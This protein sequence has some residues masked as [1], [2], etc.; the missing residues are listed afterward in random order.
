MSTQAT[1][2]RWRT[3]TLAVTLLACHQASPLGAQ[4]AS[5]QWAAIEAAFLDQFQARHPSIAAGNG[6]HAGDGGLEDFSADA[7]AVEVAHLQRLKGRIARLQVAALSPDQRVDARILDG[8]IDGWLLDLSVVKNWAR[9]PMIYASA[10]SDGVHNLMVMDHAPAATRLRLITRKLQRVP[11]FLATAQRNIPRPP[12]IFAQRAATFL[13]GAHDLISKDLWVWAATARITD[14]SALSQ[15]RAVAARADSAIMAYVGVLDAGIA[16]GLD[17]Q[18]MVG[19]SAVAARFRAEELLD[20]PLARMLAIGDSALAAEQSRFG[21]LAAQVDP[22]IT[23][24]AVWQK[25]RQRH[26]ARGE[27]VGATQRVVDELTTFVR[28][29]GLAT[30]PGRD[31]VTVAP[32]LPFDLGFASMHASPPLQQPPV[33]SYFY[34]TDVRPDATAEQAEAWLQRFSTPSVAILAAH[35]AMPGHWLHSLYMRETPG[36]I[37][38]IWIGLNPFPQPSSGQDGWAHYAEQLVVDE[39]F[40]KDD[41]SYALAQSSEALTRIVRLLSG[42][43]LHTGEWTI[44]NATQVFMSQAHLPEP[45]ARREAERG[46]YD[47]T[48]GVYFLGKR[49]LQMLRRDVEA[50]DGAGF[51]LRR[52]HER[53]MRQG[54]AP[55]WAHR[56]L[57]FPGDTR[58]VLR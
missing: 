4:S 22:A 9:N 46:T 37:R 41:P 12:R 17:G 13:R 14:R 34:V 56:Q 32:S 10:I 50:R 47:P 18:W 52:F 38:R 7:V 5:A 33:A 31:S 23:A 48:Y 58:P 45:A 42:I 20:I 25:V 15:A 27:L 30:I 19:D 49:A 57:F 3:A 16:G 1:I 55:W 40:R 39:G 43:R 36:R 8:V 11:T 2:P 26:P 28:A 54:I 24:E 35:E 29:R 51:D 53:V 44:D 21:R 6:L